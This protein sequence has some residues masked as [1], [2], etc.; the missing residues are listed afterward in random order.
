MTSIG[1]LIGVFAVLPA[2]LVAACAPFTPEVLGVNGEP[3]ST[4]LEFSADTCNQNP[5]V[6]IV[7]TSTEVRFTVTAARNDGDVND[8]LDSVDVTLEVPLGDRMVV[9]EVTNMTWAV[10]PDEGR[11]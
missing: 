7:E 5:Q 10:T 4:R 9:N 1:R 3:D 2:V 11:G 8:C 6:A